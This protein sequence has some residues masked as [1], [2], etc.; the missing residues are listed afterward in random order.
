[1]RRKG[2]GH[3]YTAASRDRDLDCK[4]FLV[5]QIAIEPTDGVQMTV[6][7]LW[8]SFVLQKKLDIVGN[9]SCGDLFNR[10]I[11]PEEKLLKVVQIVRERVCGVVSSLQVPP[12][13][14]DRVG[15]VHGC[16]LSQ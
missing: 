11:D 8:P 3:A 9:L 14:Q 15:N 7:G 1:V 2:L 16:L 10:Y 6:Y 13:A 4:V 5:V 12:V